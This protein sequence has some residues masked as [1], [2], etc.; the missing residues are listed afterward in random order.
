MVSKVKNVRLDVFSGGGCHH[1]NPISEDETIAQKRETDPALC[2]FWR[3]HALRFATD[4]I[5]V[6]EVSLVVTGSTVII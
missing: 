5:I 4:I 2:L 6:L 3:R 1:P